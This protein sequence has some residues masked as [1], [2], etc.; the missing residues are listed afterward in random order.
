MYYYCSVCVPFKTAYL[1]HYCVFLFLGNNSSVGALD[2]SFQYNFFGHRSEITLSLHN[3]IDT[4]SISE[5]RFTRVGCGP[6]G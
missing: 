3:K 2:F 1:Q 4:I 6:A 5:P